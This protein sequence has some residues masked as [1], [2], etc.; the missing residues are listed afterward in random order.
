[1]EQEIILVSL[2][3][4]VST[5]ERS[6]YEQAK[7]EVLHQQIRHLFFLFGHCKAHII[8]W[9]VSSRAYVVVRFTKFVV[10]YLKVLPLHCAYQ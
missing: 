2:P 5:A 10:S 7:A 3:D 4:S 1:M 9:T 6:E 8:L